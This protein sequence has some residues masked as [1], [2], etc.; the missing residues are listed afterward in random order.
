[1]LPEPRGGDPKFYKL[2]TIS[3]LNWAVVTPSYTLGRRRLLVTRKWHPCLALGFLPVPNSLPDVPTYVTS[4]MYAP[5]FSP[6]PLQRLTSRLWTC[7]KCRNKLQR[8]AASRLPPS[9]RYYGTS[10]GKS[11]SNGNLRGQESR[12]KRSR[13]VL[14]AATGAG[15]AGASVLAFTD[16]IKHSYEAVERTGR[17][18]AALGICIN[19]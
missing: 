11:A 7:A 17:V 1:M 18:A 6:G 5:L 16:D 2:L 12:P 19:E 9:R 8:N 14:L 3:P 13:G 15:A 10:K 4:S